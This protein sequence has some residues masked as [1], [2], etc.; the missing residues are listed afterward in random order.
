MN[1][2]KA[3]GE[4]PAS[5]T[6]RIRT[7]RDSRN[8]EPVAIERGQLVIIDESSQYEMLANCATMARLRLT[9]HAKLLISNNPRADEERASVVGQTIAIMALWEPLCQMQR[10]AFTWITIPALR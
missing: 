8:Q 5:G 7:S 3:F 6:W 2:Q 1:A 4:S 9:G 10:N